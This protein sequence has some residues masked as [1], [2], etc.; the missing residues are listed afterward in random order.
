MGNSCS[1]TQW[2]KCYG[3]SSNSRYF[4]FCLQRY[5]IFRKQPNVWGEYI[6]LVE[7]FDQFLLY[8]FKSFLPLVSSRIFIC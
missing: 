3:N 6:E 4:S 5:T 2:I 1:S 7:I 8:H